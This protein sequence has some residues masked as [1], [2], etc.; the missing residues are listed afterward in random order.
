MSKWEASR[1]TTSPQTNEAPIG[2]VPVGSSYSLCTRNLPLIILCQ[3]VGWNADADHSRVLR[4]WCPPGNAGGVRVRISRSLIS[5]MHRVGKHPDSGDSSPG[6]HALLLWQFTPDG[7]PIIARFF[8]DSLSVG[9]LL[10]LAI[11]VCILPMT[12]IG[13]LLNVGFLGT[14][15]FLTVTVYMRNLISATRMAIANAGAHLPQLM[16]AIAMG[17]IVA[18]GLPL[19]LNEI[20]GRELADYL[21]SLPNYGLRWL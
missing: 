20:C 16:P 13:L 8:A 3:L 14:M 21:R 11:G 19:L 18:I 4:S 2:T 17:F 15:P 10:A 7:A 9:T 12:L 1:R 6:R 5:I